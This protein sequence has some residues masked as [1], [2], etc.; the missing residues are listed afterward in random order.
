MEQE[1]LWQ[2]YQG[3]W[4]PLRN[5]LWAGEDGGLVSSM[6]E[7]VVDE[8]ESETAGGDPAEI[9]RAADAPPLG[10]AAKVDVAGVRAGA[11]GW[12]PVR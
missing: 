1:V 2:D 12:K 5:L 3:R 6:P 9:A 11:V 10:A 8:L 4:A 7:S